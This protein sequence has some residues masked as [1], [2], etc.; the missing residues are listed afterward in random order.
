MKKAGLVLLMGISLPIIASISA[1]AQE[2]GDKLRPSFRR[3]TV[4][5]FGGFSSLAPHDLNL[6]ADYESAYMDYYYRQSFEYNKTRSRGF[7]TYSQSL[8]PGSGF[9]RIAHSFPLGFRAKVNLSRT[10]SLSLG[11]AYLSQS[12]SSVYSVQYDIRDQDPDRSTFYYEN[13]QQITYSRFRFALRGWTPMV[14]FHA[15][16]RLIRRITLEGYIAAGVLFADCESVSEISS[17]TSQYFGF[18][19]ST[20]SFIERKGKGMG[21]ALEAG[22]QM[23]MELTKRFDVFIEGSYAYRRTR[24]I[25]GDYKYKYKKEDTN[26]DPIETAVSY[27]DAIWR[28]Y[29]YTVNNPWGQRNFSYP[30]IRDKKYLE[31]T[32]P[33][34]LDLSGF[35]I[36]AGL[37]FNF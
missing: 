12:A 4:E 20:L 14:G 5:I 15:R 21:P 27:E 3:F 31:G 29:K 28:I 25:S 23:R 7:Y 1:Q 19:Q 30:T 24:D 36:K 16:T 34:K 9:N 22:G 18:Q 37:S 13:Q 8:I 33:F 17:K 6:L 11:L 10:F 2:N 35:Q 26:S 32:D